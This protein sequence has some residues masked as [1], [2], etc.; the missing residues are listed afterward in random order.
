MKSSHVMGIAQLVPLCIGDEE[1]G[2]NQILMSLIIQIQLQ[3]MFLL[4]ICGYIMEFTFRWEESYRDG[5]DVLQQILQDANKG[6]WTTIHY[7]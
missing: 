7:L 5:S 1:P 2:E 4:K 6:F 3:K